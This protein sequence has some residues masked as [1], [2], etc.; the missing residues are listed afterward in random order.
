M[1]Q[2]K[3]EKTNKVTSKARETKQSC[4]SDFFGSKT[5]PSLQKKIYES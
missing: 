1:I 4:C 5:N 2:K 3:R